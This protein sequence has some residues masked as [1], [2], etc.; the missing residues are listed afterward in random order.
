MKSIWI[1]DLADEAVLINEV[2]NTALNNSV[3][4]RPR[5]AVRELEGQTVEVII[6]KRKMLKNKK[7]PN[8]SRSYFIMFEEADQW[9]SGS[10]PA[11]SFC[12]ATQKIP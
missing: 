5:L 1:T 3:P 6:P 9:E 4:G 7:F 12:M 8:N 10:R 11:G 2:S